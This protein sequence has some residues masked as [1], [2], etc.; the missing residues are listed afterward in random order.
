MIFKTKSI[1]YFS[2]YIL[3]LYNILSFYFI[4]KLILGKIIKYY[5]NYNFESTSLILSILIIR[6]ILIFIRKI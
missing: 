4:I 5:L 1:Y 3:C 6:K 2:I